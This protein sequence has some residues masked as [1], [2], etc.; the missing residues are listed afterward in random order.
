MNAAND[1]IEVTPE[2]IEAGVSALDDSLFPS[3]VASNSY[4]I[5]WQDLPRTVRL[6][7]LAM[8][9]V[10]QNRTTY[11]RNTSHPLLDSTTIEF[12]RDEIVKALG[13]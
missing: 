7:Y 6:V 5:S 8:Y 4:E 12:Q 3:E 13:L 1:E 9:M 10:A 11:M 2:M